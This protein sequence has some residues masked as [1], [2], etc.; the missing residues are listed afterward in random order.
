[1]RRRGN[2]RAGPVAIV[3]FVMIV[4]LVVSLCWLVARGFQKEPNGPPR[5]SQTLPAQA[6]QGTVATAPPEAGPAH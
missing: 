5:G 6:A 4:V 1:M 2:K 3:I